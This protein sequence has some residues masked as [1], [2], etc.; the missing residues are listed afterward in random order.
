[1]GL[2]SRALMVARNVLVAKPCK[3]FPFFELTR[4]FVNALN[5]KHSTLNPQPKTWGTLNSAS[6]R[7]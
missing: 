6:F 7:V 4:T 1:M 5:P 3:N 2:G